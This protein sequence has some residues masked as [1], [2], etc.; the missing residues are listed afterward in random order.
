MLV[1]TK[2]SLPASTNGLVNTEAIRSAISIAS[3][4]SA[5]VLDDFGTGYSSLASCNAR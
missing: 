5:L 1:V 3:C 4:S 2:C